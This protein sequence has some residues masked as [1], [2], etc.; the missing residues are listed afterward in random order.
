MPLRPAAISRIR[1]HFNNNS[2]QCGSPY[3]MYMKHQ[4][5]SST[6]FVNFYF[7]LNNKTLILP[8]TVILTK[9]TRTK[10][11]NIRQ[12][13]QQFVRHKYKVKNK[14]VCVTEKVTV[15]EAILKFCVFSFCFL[16]FSSN[17][18]YEKTLK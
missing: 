2:F 16:C 9:T 1:K 14:L 18:Q 7:F 6:R 17:F 4:K 11:A 13:Q 12:Q 15:I 8:F 10:R 5:L 3:N